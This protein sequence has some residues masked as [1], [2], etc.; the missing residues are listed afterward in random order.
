[1]S[2]FAA[3]SNYAAIVRPL[4]VLIMVIA[5]LFLLRVLRVA[6]LST[7]PAGEEGVRRRSKGT[8]ALEFIEPAERAGER[9]DV[10]RPLTVGRGADCELSLFDTYLSTRHARFLNDG[11]ELTVEHLGSTNG[12]YLNQELVEGRVALE[13]GDII[14][15]GG[16]LFEVVR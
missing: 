14:Q 9:V 8:L 5:A 4:Q 1:M 16:V 11:G 13:R 15:V 12:T 3:S 10:D 7:Q 2:L 6:T